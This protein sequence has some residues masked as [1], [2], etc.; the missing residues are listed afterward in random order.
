MMGTKSPRGCPD[1]VQLVRMVKERRSLVKEYLAAASG[2]KPG[3][4]KPP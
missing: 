4:E 3:D 2:G 1:F